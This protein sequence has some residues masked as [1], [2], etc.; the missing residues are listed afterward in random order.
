MYNDIKLI[1]GSIHIL[2]S[3]I[4]QGQIRAVPIEVGLKIKMRDYVY[5][6]LINNTDIQSKFKLNVKRLNR[7]W[8]SVYFDELKGDN[9]E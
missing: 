7:W 8:Y 5:K 2:D 1:D 4:K 9:Y 6:N 3:D